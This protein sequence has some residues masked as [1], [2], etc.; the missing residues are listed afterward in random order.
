LDN[1]PVEAA[2]KKAVL[3]RKNAYFYKTANGAWVGDLF[4]SLIQT[5]ELNQV[6]PFAYLSALHEHADAL[7]AHPDA[8][9]PWTYQDTLHKQTPFAAVP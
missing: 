6:N 3:H 5:C 7:P 4:M 1:S 9:M 2:L 8:W